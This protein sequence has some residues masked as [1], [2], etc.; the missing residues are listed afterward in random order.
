MERLHWAAGLYSFLAGR[1]FDVLDE[2][3]SWIIGTG[4]CNAFMQKWLDDEFSVLARF[5]RFALTPLRRMRQ[6]Q[7]SGGE[8]LAQHLVDDVQVRIRFHADAHS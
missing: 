8:P 6:F 3:K 1:S 4:R 7:S 2:W 5:H